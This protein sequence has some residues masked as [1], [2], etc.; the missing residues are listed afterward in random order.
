MSIVDVA[1]R[2]GVSPATVSR[3]LRGLAKVS[4]ETRQRVLT[5]ARDLDYVTSLQASSIASG[6][7]R[8]IAVIV[9]FITRWFFSSVTAG[10]VDALREQGFD[11]MLYHL[12]DA[13]V[14]DRFFRQMP[15]DSRVEGIMTLSMPL[16]E[17]HT[18][19]LRAL[20]IPLV[21][22]GIAV[23]GSASVGIDET[24]AARSAVNHLINLRHERIG[25]IVG[26]EDD[27]RFDFM[28]STDRS[29]GWADA[30]STAGLK[31]SDQLVATGPHG[32]E[33]GA[34]AMARLLSRSVLPTAVF[35]EY[36]ELAIGA[37][38]A[39]RRAGLR[40]PEDISVIGI[41]DHEMA[42]MLD[43]TTVAQDVVGQGAIAARLMI[44][45]LT[46]ERSGTPAEMITVPT[47]L[48][49]RGSTAPPTGTITAA[50]RA[51]RRPPTRRRRSG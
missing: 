47:Q 46:G 5:A 17:D 44:R 7:R 12:G 34:A 37:L 19:A 15:V 1:E 3:S 6:P 23:P 13:D 51:I 32:L 45:T 43:L 36:D 21:S 42:S 14:R 33:G 9:P 8:T 35:A 41:D 10:A 18:L 48:V 24:A 20:D 49:L 22:V 40:V 4:A 29:Q 16:T 28:S 26:E 30:L 50:P 11:V 31:T 38:W 39:L 25:L 27:P 2:A